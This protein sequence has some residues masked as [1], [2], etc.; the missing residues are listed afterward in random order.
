MLPR[1]IGEHVLVGFVHDAGGREALRF[2]EAVSATTGGRL[3]VATV[4]PQDRAGGAAEAQ[5]TLDQAAALLGE[6]GSAAE[7]VAHESRGAGRGLSVLAS[8]LGA[9]V[10]V[11]GSPGGGARGRIGIGATADKLLHSAF[12]AV[13][14]V[15]ADYAPPERLERITVAYVRRPQC[16]EAVRRAAEAARRL[17][18]SLRLLT[19]A[20]DDDDEDRLRDD[21][22][23]A[24]PLATEAAGLPADGVAT[25]LVAGA[26]VAAA[27][28]RAGWTDGELLVCASSED[29]T[30]HQVFLGE[31]A[32]KVLRAATCPVAVLP[33]GYD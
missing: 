5:T 22:A 20:L 4:H 23:L 2:A 19:L 30:A 10:I 18:A 21:L 24:A 11:V 1:M 14:L 15:P 7:F 9:D 17:G 33:R 3:T 8:R 31:V 29:A 26:D 6:N 13:L 32:L 28:D 12:E 25:E 16:E 27:M